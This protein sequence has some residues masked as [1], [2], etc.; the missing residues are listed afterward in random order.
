MTTFA[1]LS[2]FPV[3]KAQVVLPGSGIWH[4]DIDLDRVPPALPSP[5]IFSFAN[6][7]LIGTS[8]RFVDFTSYRSLRMVGGM[9]GWRT[10]LP[11][12]QYST[13]FLSTVVLD[14]AL[15]VGE[16]VILTTDKLLDNFVRRKAPA[17]L[18]L[19]DLFQD[20]W[21]M[22]LQG[23]V[24]TDPR[25][26]SVVTSLFAANEVVGYAGLY[27]IETDSPGDWTPNASFFGP[28][29]SGT[30][31]RVTHTIHEGSLRT[32]VMVS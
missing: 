23:F 30:V 16:T 17:S 1:N 4:A 20:V 3:T 7:T 10:V 6:L 8:V 26:P 14:A 12:K 24:H 9:G 2:G 28:T 13:P 18:I 11:P 21:W 22:D 27:V 29:V 19:Q 31:N 32:E 25:L 5:L 15:T